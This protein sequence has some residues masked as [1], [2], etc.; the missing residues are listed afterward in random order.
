ML[1]IS[2]F[3][4]LEFL[5]LLPSLREGSDYRMTSQGVAI[6]MR[7]DILEMFMA[8]QDAT[9][10]AANLFGMPGA[11]TVDGKIGPTTG[12]AVKFTVGRFT[13]D[14]RE[15]LT[16]EARDGIASAVAKDARNV[17]GTLLEAINRKS[18]APIVATPIA[19]TIKP[20]PFVLPVV[21]VQ[22]TKPF[23]LPTVIV[24]PSLKPST[25]AQTALISTTPTKPKLSTAAWAAVMGAFLVAGIGAAVLVAKR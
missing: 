12:A 11:I 9:N 14:L 17:L 3:G 6:A 18:S 24:Q 23:V 10:R 22:A 4:E 5:G 8:L 1:S 15:N 7:P 21:T 16:A 25:A 13:D 2:S 19:P 20:Q